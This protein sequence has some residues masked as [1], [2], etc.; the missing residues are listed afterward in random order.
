MNPTIAT[1]KSGVCALVRTTW[2]VP[3][4]VS[5]SVSI[6]SP[7]SGREIV[8]PAERAQSSERGYLPLYVP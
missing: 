8:K 7:Y 4:T 5:H 2:W 3:L 6:V 1:Q